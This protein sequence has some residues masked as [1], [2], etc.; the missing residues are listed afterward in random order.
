MPVSVERANDLYV[1]LL[2]VDNTSD[3]HTA[4]S[5]LFANALR[6]TLTVTTC[7]ST[8]CS[9]IS[10]L[11]LPTHIRTFANSHLFCVS[12][13]GMAKRDKEEENKMDVYQQ[14]ALARKN[15]AKCHCQRL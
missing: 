1:H 10:G 2:W 5:F 4:I 9:T 7:G 13:Q 12:H 8:C 3:E 6:A 11:F 14:E 15:C